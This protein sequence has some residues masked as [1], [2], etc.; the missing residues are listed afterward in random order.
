MEMP[1]TT[2][3]AQPKQ[4]SVTLPVLGIGVTTTALALFIVWLINYASEDFNIMGF[5]ANWVIPVGA[6]GVGFLA[7]SG[8]GLAAWWLNRRVSAGLYVAVGLLQV[9][10]Y[11]AAQYEEYR[12]LNPPNADGS[13]MSFTS[14]FDITTRNMA[15]KS[16]H[17]REYGK[18]VGGWGYFFR[19]LE[20]F[21]FALGGLLV[22][23]ILSRKPYCDGCSTYMKSKT[24]G[25]LPAGVPLKSI[26]KKD[27]EAKAAYDQ[28][29]TEAYDQAM[30]TVAELGTLAAQGKREELKAVFVPHRPNYRA[31]NKLTCRMEVALN[32][33]PVCGRGTL[34][35]TAVRGV[36]KQM[37]RA[38]AAE[39]PFEPPAAAG[40]EQP[41]AG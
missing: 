30:A 10:A 15:F 33:C 40:A 21:G 7:G 1:T 2:E 35:A 23:L 25:Y 34:I 37:V 31:F 26:K 38:K 18:P 19:G 9:G 8:Y 12:H 29:H 28:A 14:Y 27:V 6:I 4:R 36:G 17:E 32:T 41:V 16:Q 20:V 3:S 39:L 5:Y 11:F 22:P 13:P 24:L